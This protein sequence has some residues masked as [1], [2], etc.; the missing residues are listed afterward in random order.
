LAF[1]NNLEV[2][3]VE[4]GSIEDYTAKDLN[5]RDVH[6]GAA[7][8]ATAAAPRPPWWWRCGRDR[9]LKKSSRQRRD[10]GRF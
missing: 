10:H 9:F 6:G 2:I 1:E 4:Y 5:T 3:F 7:A 8:A